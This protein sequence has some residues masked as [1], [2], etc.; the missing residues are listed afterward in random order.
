[1]Q[2][3]SG[4]VQDCA[5]VSGVLTRRNRFCTAMQIEMALRVTKGLVA[6]FAAREQVPLFDELI[7]AM[8]AL[9]SLERYLMQSSRHTQIIGVILEQQ[10]RDHALLVSHCMKEIDPSKE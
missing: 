6:E 7:M 3:F 9:L 8:A 10:C 5:D 2:Y 4:A 1:M